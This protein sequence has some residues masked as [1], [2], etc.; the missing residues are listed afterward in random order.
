MQWL[1][2]L[3]SIVPWFGTLIWLISN[4]GTRILAL[5]KRVDEHGE[6][7]KAHYRHEGVRAIHQESLSE[8]TLDARFEDLANRQQGLHRESQLRIEMMLR[9]MEKMAESQDWMARRWD[10]EIAPILSVLRLK[11]PELFK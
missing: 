3:V 4:H 2:V 7:H 8:A 9:S 1:P 5:E 11:V 10:G 6:D